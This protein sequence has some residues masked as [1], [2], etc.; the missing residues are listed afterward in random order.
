MAQVQLTPQAADDVQKLPTYIKSRV[1]DVIARLADWPNVSGAK[2]MRGELKGAF[3][4]R[5]GDYR[6]VFTVKGNVVVVFRV[7][8]RRDVYER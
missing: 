1:R 5:T 4:I 8:N 3:R 6:V 7:D 2:P